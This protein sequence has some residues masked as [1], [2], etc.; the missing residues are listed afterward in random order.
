MS[1]DSWEKQAI[2]AQCGVDR[3]SVS[4]VARKHNIAT[5][6]LFRWRRELGPA[7][8]AKPAFVPVAL[9]ALSG[10][11]GPAPVGTAV[12]DGGV[13]EIEL[14]GGRRVRVAGAVDVVALRR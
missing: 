7:A 12:G 2:V 10:A 11:E 14:S 4:A 13:I 1:G 3:A 5:S 6:L 8:E 9:P